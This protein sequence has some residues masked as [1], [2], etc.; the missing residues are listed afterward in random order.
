LDFVDIGAAD[1]P[2]L[3]SLINSKNV[4]FCKPPC[5]IEIYACYQDRLPPALAAVTGCDVVASRGEKCG[6]K[7]PNIWYGDFYRHSP[8][9][10]M[11]RIGTSYTP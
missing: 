9:G 3:E 4:K 1:V 2:M 10:S 5:I 11:T 6:A 8:D 7:T